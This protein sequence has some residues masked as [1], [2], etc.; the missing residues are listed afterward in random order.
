MMDGTPN[1]LIWSFIFQLDK[2]CF[3]GV[4]HAAGVQNRLN[5]HHELRHYPAA[6]CKTARTDTF[7]H[8]P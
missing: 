6:T 4:N 1:R 8:S 7:I 3:C 2:V 5:L